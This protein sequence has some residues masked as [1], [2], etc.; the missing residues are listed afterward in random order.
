MRM[1]RVR[2]TVRTMMVAVV[3]VA[4]TLVFAVPACQHVFWLYKKPA[5]L[6]GLEVENEE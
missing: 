6:I 4:L 3:V 5:R 2:F 1:P